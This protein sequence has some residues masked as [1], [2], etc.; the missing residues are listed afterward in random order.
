MEG[1]SMKV[2]VAEAH[3]DAR[4]RLVALARGMDCT[5]VA[6]ADDGPAA[7]SEFA[8]S[9]P[10]VAVLAIDLPGLA[11]PAAADLAGEGGH[12]LMIAGAELLAL[13][14]RDLL[15]A[16]SEEA[17]RLGRLMDVLAHAGLDPDRAA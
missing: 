1:S 16:R 17:E 6:E 8:R 13:V 3:R 4:S 10:D 12:D 7:L 15:E 5:V 2:L 14:S 11:V 9:R